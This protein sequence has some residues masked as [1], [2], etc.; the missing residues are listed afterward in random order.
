MSDLDVLHDELQI[1]ISTLKILRYTDA[2]RVV[3][4]AVRVLGAL[5]ADNAE[6]AGR[7]QCLTCGRYAP[8]G[9]D[10]YYEDPACTGPEDLNPC[11][12]DMTPQEAADYWRT[13]WHEQHRE[14]VDLKEQLAHVTRQLRARQS[15]PKQYTRW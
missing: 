2:A 9:V 11:L 5:N 4:D 15:Y 6:L 3:E 8:A 12:F 10:R 13:R 7:R 14:L 1:V